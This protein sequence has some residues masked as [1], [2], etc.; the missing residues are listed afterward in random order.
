LLNAGGNNVFLINPNGVIITKTGTINANRFVAS[1]SSMSDGDM[2]KFAKSTQEQAAAFS[3]VFKPHKAGNVVNMG[4]INANDVLLIGNKVDIQG[5]KLG[6]KNSTTHLVGKNVYI[7]A[8]SANLNSTINV[9]AT[10]GGYIQRQMINF[11]NDGY[12]FGNNAN[13]N[14]VNYTDSSGTTHTGS[15]NFKKALTI[16]N[17]GD[18]KKNAIEWWHFAKGW[19]ENLG[20]REIDEFRLVG[21][22]D[23]SGNKGQGTEGKDWQNYANYCIDGLGCTS[24]IVGY[25]NSFNKIFDGQGYTLKNINIDITFD[26]VKYYSQLVGIFGGAESGAIFRNINVDYMGGGIKVDINSDGRYNIGGF[27]GATDTEGGNNVKFSNISINNINNITINGNYSVDE[28]AEYIDGVNAGGFAGNYYGSTAKN[29]FINNIK[30]IE[31]KGFNAKTGGFAGSISYGDISSVS[32]SNIG[33]IS[34]FINYSNIGFSRSG[35]FAGSI[36]LG[37]YFILSNI[38]DISISNIGNISS[39]GHKSYSGGFAGSISLGRD[40]AISNISVSDIASINSNGDINYDSLSHSGGFA[41]SIYLE[42]DN[43]ISNISVGDITSINSKSNEAYSGGFAGYITTTMY[44]EA[45]GVFKNISLNNISKINSTSSSDR[46][47]KKGS[48]G[49]FA[50]LVENGVY[51]SDIYIFFNPRVEINSNNKVGKFAGHI[52]NIKVD[53]IHIY[54]H[55]NDLANATADQSFWNDF[56]KN[57]YVSDKIN[58]HTYNDSTQSDA[59]KDFLSKANTIEKPSKPTNPTDPTDPTDPSNPDVILD[60]DD[61]YGGIIASIINEIRNEKYTIDIKNLVSLINAFKGLDKDSSE[62]EIKA[63]IKTHLGID[64]DKALSMAQSISFLL[65]YQ[66][67]NF[68]GRLSEQAK[69]IY[70]GTIKP[71]VSNTLGLISYLDKNKDYLLEQY[72]KHKE[73]EQVFKDKEQAYKKAEAEFNRLLDLVNKG[74]LSYNDLNSLKL[75]ITGLMLIMII[76]IYQ[77]ISVN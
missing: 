13:I 26:E 31:N 73:L 12:K 15:S 41:G 6:N 27:I 77:M 61:L 5:G 68:D 14:V 63:V 1:T 44:D 32:I 2:W 20:V 50:G 53:N 69:T 40:N 59:Y 25:E 16:G 11:A 60:S 49:G 67:H 74:K 48:S 45:G 4:N 39:N 9:T 23:F 7:D 47:F 30:N 24:M 58:I 75:L 38:S 10:E 19:N 70:D 34:S 55:I 64:G 57:D 33:N 52:D 3:P 56:N 17:M 8:D 18:E 36:S 71:N 28:P 62:N 35:G 42:R 72:N 76:M 22:I 21:N 65:N 29:I 43:A 66:E 46:I 51:F 54:H 37:D